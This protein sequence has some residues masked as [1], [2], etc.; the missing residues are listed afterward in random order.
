M[1]CYEHGPPSRS[2]VAKMYVPR[3]KKVASLAFVT[4][5]VGC[6]S[7]TSGGLGSVQFTTTG[8]DFI[9][10]EIPALAVEDG[11]TIAYDRFLVT[12]ADIEVAERIGVPPLVSMPG[13]KLFNQKVQGD[14]S[15]VTFP[16]I[17]VNLYAHTSYRI[18]PAVQDTELGPGITSDDKAFMVNNGYA[19]YLEAHATSA[20]GVKTF[21]WGFSLDTLYDRCRGEVSGKDLDGVV[22]TNGGTDTVQLTIH[23]DHLFYD[24][25]QSKDAKIRFQNIAD[26]DADGNGDVTLE[27]LAKVELATIPAEN[28][29]Y[30]TG[31]AA[32]VND[33]R[34][35]V[36][37]LSRT[38]GHFRG[39]GQCFVSTR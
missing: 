9:E 25:L 17:P 34:A 24:D 14:K 12:F 7:S 13:S 10:K 21:K 18:A 2:N 20:T 36:E 5:F 35:F 37:A 19:V 11:W 39:D 23:G 8:G 3:M 27:E 4:A 29:P 15:I 32:N 38:M 22:V 28:G 33:L 30:G 6:S 26:A 16:S 31:S 1:A